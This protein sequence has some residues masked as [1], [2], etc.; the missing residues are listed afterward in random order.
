MPAATRVPS[1]GRTCRSATISPA[2]RMPSRVRRCDRAAGTGDLGGGHLPRR[3]RPTIPSHGVSWFEAVAYA[4]FRGKELPDGLP[5]VPRRILAERAAGIARVGHHQRKQFRWA[6]ALRR[7][8]S[9]G[10][11]PY[12]TYD[13]AG[14]VREWLW[15][16]VAR[17][18]LDRRAAPGT[19]HR[20]S[21]TSS[22]RRRLG[23]F[24]RQRLSLHAH[25]ARAGLCRATAR[26]DRAEVG[27][28][29]GARAGRG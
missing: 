13:M 19:R 2:G 9:K 29:R 18:P 28:L 16:V 20:I 24:A 17:R 5:L 21:T 14:N 27:R 15:N 1:S 3:H 4:R 10:I 11:G 22:T 25:A 23:P 26:A 7:W 6:R 8:A 12:G